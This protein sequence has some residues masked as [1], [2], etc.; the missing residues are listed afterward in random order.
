[1]EEA[2]IAE[3]GLGTH[4][5]GD[6]SACALVLDVEGPDQERLLSQILERLQG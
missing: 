1:L 6:R 5:E 3:L 2:G 4:A